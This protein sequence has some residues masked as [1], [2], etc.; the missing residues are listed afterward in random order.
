MP[1]FPFFFSPLV[2][3]LSLSFHSFFLFFS[4]PIFFQVPWLLMVPQH[5][6]T[7]LWGHSVLLHGSVTAFC[8]TKDVII[9]CCVLQA[10]QAKKMQRSGDQREKDGTCCFYTVKLENMYED[11]QCQHA[12]LTLREGESKGMRER[13]KARGIERRWMLTAFKTPMGILCHCILAPLLLASTISHHSMYVCLTPSLS[14]R[15]SHSLLLQLLAASLLTLP[16]IPF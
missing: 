13:A 9:A 15:I 16:S 8:N 12:V 7:V 11:K 3:L 6:S 2:L 1:S 14:E 10:L 5:A 4:P